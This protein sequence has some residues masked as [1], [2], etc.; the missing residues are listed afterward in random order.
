MKFVIMKTTVGTRE[1]YQLHLAAHLAYLEEL[2]ARNRLLGAGSYDD[3]SGGLLFVEVVGLEEALE[4]AQ[5]DPLVEAGVESYQVRGWTQTNTSDAAALPG[6]PSIAAPPSASSGPIEPHPSEESFRVVDAE[7]DARFA[8]ILETCLPGA[9]LASGDP[10]RSDYLRRA[11]G[12]GLKKLLLLHEDKI[13]GQLELA[14][15]EASGLPISGEGVTVIHCLW[16]SDAY[17]GLDGGQLLLA[18]CS[19]RTKAASLATIAFNATLPWMPRSYFERQGFAAI[20]QL[21]TGRFYGNTPIVAY[22][23]WRPLLPDVPAPSWDRSLIPEGLLFCPRYPWLAGKRLYWG[24]HYDYF[25]VLV[26]EGLR[27]PGLLDQLPVLETRRTE[28][29][30]LVKFGLPSADLMSALELI[31]ASLIADP[32]YYAQVYNAERL[33][34]VYPDRIFH[35]TADRASW[36]EAI[37]YGRDKGIPEDELVFVPNLFDKTFPGRA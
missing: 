8:T 11:G 17:S 35:A 36:A 12:R 3:R 2:R 13:A 27:R 7:S 4:I 33:I 37:R 34:I 25:G 1:A 14:P 32:T 9:A 26:T 22:L 16:V 10:V 28:P 23:M 15:P 20:D 21:A 18:A 24:D 30:T 19:E 29:W 31:Q 6:E 5:R